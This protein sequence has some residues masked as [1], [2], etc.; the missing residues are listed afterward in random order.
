MSTYRVCA[1]IDL[2][3]F[4]HN[5]KEIQKKIGPGTGLMGVIK[6][7]AYGHG[8]VILAKE[9]ERLGASWLAVACVE[10]GIELRKNNIR[11]PILVLG[12]T[13]EDQ[14]KDLLDYNIT[15][16]VFS[17][18]MA[19]AMDRAAAAAGKVLPVHIK[20]DTGMGH[21]GY[22]PTRES[23]QEIYKI[24]GLEHICVEGMFT[25][26]ACADM[27]DE[28]S[29]AVTQQQ[30]DRYCQMEQWLGEMGLHIPVRHCANSAGIMDE[31][32]MH[33]DMVRAGIILYGLYPSDEMPRSALDLKSVMSLKSHITYIKNVGPG[34]GISY[35]HTYVTSKETAVATIPVGYGD[36]YPRLLSNQGSVLIGGKRA[37]IIGRVCMDQF[38][39]DI[40]GM[41]HVCE[42]DEVTLVGC[43]GSQEITFDELAGLTGT[44]SYE[45]VCDV[46]RRVPRVYIKN[47]NVAAV[48]SCETV[49]VSNLPED[50]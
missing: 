29:K 49:T 2:D 46:G 39:V 30:Y 31:P 1:R 40:T 38:M 9:L 12:Y 4:E 19:K 3:A 35:G 47:G 37:P 44:I 6:T 14:Y 8:A 23:A 24:S 25:H 43:D 13:A 26:F 42:G 27:E 11:L 28:Q 34:E 45:L 50:Q 15:P 22:A 10:E 21:I 36:G 33:K 7:N 18:E 17:L 41:D 20:V 48:S 16:A 32:E 5:V